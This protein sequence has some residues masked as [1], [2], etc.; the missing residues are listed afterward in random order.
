MKT[1]KDNEVY[2]WEYDTILDVIER[3][4]HFI[5][6]I[7]NRKRPHSSLGYVSPEEFEQ[8]IE[9]EYPNNVSRPLLEI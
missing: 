6:E 5:E 3:L 2:C 8:K 7:Y 9:V 1:L 4:P